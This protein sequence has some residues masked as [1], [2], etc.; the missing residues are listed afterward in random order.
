MTKP[1]YGLAT[2]IGRKN[3]SSKLSYWIVEYSGDYTADYSPVVITDNLST[4]SNHRSWDRMFP[5]MV[6]GLNKSINTFP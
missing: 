3:K 5:Q 2:K 4:G 6:N 1:R